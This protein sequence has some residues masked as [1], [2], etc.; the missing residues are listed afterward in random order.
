[1]NEDLL[2]FK[3]SCAA[4]DKYVILLND[5]LFSDTVA[6]TAF[7]TFE[8]LRW[9][10]TSQAYLKETPFA[11]SGNYLG[12]ASSVAEGA[13]TAASELNKVNISLKDHRSYFTRV[14]SAVKNWHKIPTTLTLAPLLPRSGISSVSN[15]N[16][17][18]LETKD[19]MAIK[20]VR[21]SF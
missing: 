14:I 13:K 4:S 8:S 12:A 11:G 3:E 19:M 2:M 7:F 6:Q 9:T 5:M 1:M 15:P 16:I 21:Q 17:A 18:P 20:E 10:S